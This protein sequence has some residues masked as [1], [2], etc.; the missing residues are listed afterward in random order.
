MRW[1]ARI[2]R[3]EPFLNSGKSEC[4]FLHSGGVG[5]IV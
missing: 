1:N 5:I 4:F 2:E 3:V